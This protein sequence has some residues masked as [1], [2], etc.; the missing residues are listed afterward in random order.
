MKKLLISFFFF[1]SFQILLIQPTLAAPA[2]WG[3]AINSS[4]NECAGYWAGDEHYQYFLPHGWNAYYPEEGIIT[5][6]FGVCDFGYN[7]EEGCCEQ[8]GLEFVSDN[9]GLYD[10][11]DEEKLG[12]LY[13]PIWIISGI[14]IC[15]F[16]VL[17]VISV[18]FVFLYIRKKSN[19]KKK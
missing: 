4:T 2:P 13:D 18:I 6:P 8:L 11:D 17:F 12:G 10:R 5:T 9:I 1:I 15:V 7:D 19:N 14:C 16:F 3:I